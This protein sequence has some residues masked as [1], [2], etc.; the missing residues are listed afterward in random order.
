LSLYVVA[1]PIG[2]LLDMTQRAIQVLTD[3]DVI[4]A[5][6]TRHSKSLLNHFGIST[7]LVAFHDHNEKTGSQSLV[8]RMLNGDQVALVSDAGTPLISDP[9][10]QLVR[11]AHAAS[12]TVVPIPGPTA[13]AAA[14]SASGL[15]TDSFLFLGFL[16]S[17]STA[18]IAKLQTLRY[19]PFSLVFYEAP[20]RID[21]SISS[22]IDVFGGDRPACIA[23][24]MTKTFEQIVNGTLAELLAGLQSRE[25]VSKGE[26]VVVVS[27]VSDNN[28]EFDDRT[29]LTHL[30][31]ELAPSKAAALAHKLTGKPK[32]AFYELALAIKHE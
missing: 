25:I 4:A 12:I 7:P 30:L 16:P 14:L 5:E 21:K 19:Y 2:N 11:D 20:H 18:R 10:Y 23:R 15:A 8:A 32:K 28:V 6:D 22:M 17:K 1:T 26:F 9:G 24:E 31:A 13:M 29:L 27:G 3:V